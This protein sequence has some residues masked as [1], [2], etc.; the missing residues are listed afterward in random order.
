MHKNFP[1]WSS[2]LVFAR[3]IANFEVCHG[4]HTHILLLHS[5]VVCFLKHF[6]FLPEKKST[7]KFDLPNIEVD[8]KRCYFTIAKSSKRRWHHYL[9][10]ATICYFWSLDHSRP[11]KLMKS[12]KSIFFLC[13]IAFLAVLNFFLVQ[14]LISGHF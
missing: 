13:K 9:H 10:S 7:L 14:K 2:I 5:T 6:A 11:K 3:K 4:R 1:I 12:N 8:N